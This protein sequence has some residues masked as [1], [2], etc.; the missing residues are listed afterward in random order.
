MSNVSSVTKYFPTVNE[1]Y[2][3][4]LQTTI[5]PGATTVGLANAT[6]LTNGSIFVGIIEPGGNNQQVFT[7][8]VDVTGSQITG[9]VWTR[10]ANVTHYAGVTI[11]DYVAGTGF[12]MI[13]TGILKFA[14]QYGELA[15]PYLV[16]PDRS[17]VVEY[18]VSSNS[19]N[20]LAIYSGP[21]GFDVAIKA[22]GT[23]AV[24]PLDLQSTGSDLKGGGLRYNGVG[25][26]ALPM[27]WCRALIA[28]QLPFISQSPSS[29]WGTL[30]GSGYNF[31]ASTQTTPVS[32]GT[33]TGDTISYKIYLDAGTYTFYHYAIA[34]ADKG[35]MHIA[36]ID[37]KGISYTGSDQDMYNASTAQYTITSTGLNFPH[38][39]YVTLQVS[40]SGKNASATAYKLA[41]TGCQILRTA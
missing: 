29:G 41:Y 22:V 24:V 37:E 35:I 16:G 18:S 7:G 31:P 6:G 36:I 20:H 33:V 12:N 14:N 39:Q 23:D 19:V 21:T 9:V 32:P 11:V 17:K 25:F 4:T 15:P 28:N 27:D 10:G 26:R 30:S 8:T 1:G 13:T 2:N 34:G 40:V 3:T 38:G 5:A